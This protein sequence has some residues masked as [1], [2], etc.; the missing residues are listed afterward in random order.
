M[1]KSVIAANAIAETCDEIK[2][3]LLE[4]NASYGNS[5]FDPI[6]VFNKTGAKSQIGVRIDDK[7]PR[8]KQGHEFPGD[9]T[10][11]DLA[12]YLII[13]IAYDKYETGL[14]QDSKS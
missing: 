9:D 11:K 14:S 4:K 12:G 8:L 13:L 1:S 10:V 5:A 2:A 3:F 7:L 6:G